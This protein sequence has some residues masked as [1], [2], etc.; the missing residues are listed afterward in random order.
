MSLLISL[1]V[2]LLI[3]NGVLASQVVYEDPVPV[4]RSALE[5]LHYLPTRSHTFHGSWCRHGWEHIYY[6]H[7]STHAGCRLVLDTLY[8]Y[9]HYCLF[10]NI[11]TLKWFNKQQHNVVQFSDRFC[12][13][14]SCSLLLETNSPYPWAGTF[15][16][17]NTGSNY[18]HNTLSPTENCK[19]AFVSSASGACN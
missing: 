14:M 4:L 3:E 12:V 15:D 18:N 1:L 5:Y 13:E 2:T 11:F 7:I 19:Y 8:L 6:L 16:V 10:E 9:R 17:Q